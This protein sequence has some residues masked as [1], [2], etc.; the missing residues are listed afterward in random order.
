MCDE[1]PKNQWG[2]IKEK[3]EQ[4]NWRSI[5]GE[6]RRSF[7]NKLRE[8][9]LDAQ[10]NAESFDGLLFAFEQMGAYRL[11]ETSTLGSYR[12]SLIDLALQSPLKGESQYWHSS[13]NVLYECI[14]EGRNDALHQGARARHLTMHCIEFGLMLEDALMNGDDPMTLLKDIMV[15]SVIVAQ[16]WQPVGFVRKIMLT[17]SFTYLPIFLN[18]KWQV[19]SDAQI[20][21]M[22]R[23]V[24][25]DKRG[26]L[27]AATLEDRRLHKHGLKFLDV[28]VERPRVSIADIAKTLL[29]QPI[30]LVVD[31]DKKTEPASC[32]HLVGI[33]TPFD[34]L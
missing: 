29:D 22:L 2:R 28:H 16:V 4:K 12:P 19:V 11:S 17:N 14:L 34:I 8:A 31:A 27:L 15:Q 32:K 3:N 13:A 23:S 7:L 24:N 18:G 9:R 5:G 20:A 21:A 30:V 1:Q 6:A 25:Q 33:V 10:K 26:L